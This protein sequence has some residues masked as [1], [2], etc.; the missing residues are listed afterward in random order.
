M[1]EIRPDQME[2]F[3]TLAQA[4][5]VRRATAYLREAHG[6]ALRGITAPE[7]T[8]RIQR[9]MGIAAGYEVSGE[10]DVMQFVEVS[11]VFGDDFHCS[12]R[13]PAAERVLATKADGATKMRH[14]LAA[15][16]TEFKVPV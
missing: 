2:V 10:A 7:L 16:Q 12:S 6:E 1:I 5:F 9:Q 14:L 13:Y 11:L 4:S 3:A 8:D 15:A